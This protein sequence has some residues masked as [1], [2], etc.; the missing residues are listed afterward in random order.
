MQFFTHTQIDFM[1]F[2]GFFAVL[3]GA[4]VVAS[5]VMLFTMDQL[6]LGIDFAGGTQLTLK[7]RAPT[8][9]DEL[10]TVLAEAGLPEAQ[11]Q[12]FGE[13]GANEKII[14]S[15]IA[16]SREGE[17]DRVVGEVLSAL[18]ARFNQGMA[19]A[20]LNRL[21]ARELAGFL[22]TADPDAVA[23]AGE[24]AA[25]HYE[26]AAE[27]IMEVKRG[28]GLFASWDEVRQAQ[29]VSPEALAHLESQGH[30]GEFALLGVESVGPQIG[31][32]LRRKGRLA[33]IL[34]LVAMLVYI[35]LRFELRFGVGAVVALAH[36][37][38]ITLALFAFLGYEFN[39]ATIAAF[40]TL[41]GYSVNDT[42][43]VFD[44]VR[45]NLRSAR[46]EP[47][48]EILNRS[49]NQTLSRTFLTSITT[50]LVVGTLFLFGG[51]VLRGFA[52]VLLIGIVV[53]TYSSVFIA[54]PVVLL[55]EKYS[56]REV[57]SRRGATR[58]AESR[59]S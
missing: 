48:V 36:D 22:Q 18:D 49:L 16:G 45:E 28:L 35:W 40:L 56:G 29:G 13:E 51:D 6:N 19:G 47:L 12:R 31:G 25:A 44:R 46:R 30:L 32:E 23:A 1:K 41:A 34:S 43:V 11:I 17:Q 50:L 2:R 53:G 42:V 55:W 21:G 59:A 26:A 57:R 20:D 14:K 10:R 5:A 37:V 9:T 8:E 15:P 39:L 38:L 27:A 33:V 58:A 4:L 7:F 54:S 52:F 24:A 3:S